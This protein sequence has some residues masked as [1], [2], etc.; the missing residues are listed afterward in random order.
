MFPAHIW[1]MCSRTLATM[2]SRPVDDEPSQKGF[3]TINCVNL[4]AI[5]MDCRG[6]RSTST[7]EADGLTS[8]AWRTITGKGP[9]LTLHKPPSN[10]HGLLRGLGATSNRC[11]C[12][13]PKRESLKES[14]SSTLMSYTKAEGCC[15]VPENRCRYPETG[16]P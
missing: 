5:H 15:R 14:L 8:I 3:H 13:H 11:A 4:R 1:P 16:V 10:P 2:D 7:R 12:M 9:P 6:S